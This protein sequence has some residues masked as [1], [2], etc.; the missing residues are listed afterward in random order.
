MKLHEQRR[1][2]M[3]LCQSGAKGYKIFIL[4]QLHS[5][6]HE[7][8]EPELTM[9]CTYIVLCSYTLH[10]NWNFPSNHKAHVFLVIMFHITLMALPHQTLMVINTALLPA[11]SLLHPKKHKR[12]NKYSS[13]TCQLFPHQAQLVIS[14]VLPPVIHV[15]LAH[16]TQT[17]I[18]TAL[19]PDSC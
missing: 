13:D 11:T 18:N 1:I 7:D 17:G 10:S 16:Q 12:G 6:K 14:T 19:L 3:H 9:Y 4:L 8:I 5:P 15:A 2:Y